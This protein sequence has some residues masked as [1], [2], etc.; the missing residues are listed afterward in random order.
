MDKGRV[1]MP[2]GL[3]SSLSGYLISPQQEGGGGAEERMKGDATEEMRCG[4]SVC[5]TKEHFF[6][7]P[8]SLFYWIGNTIFFKKFKTR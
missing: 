4:T 1:M 6:F 5:Q 7:L 2:D 3:L 8:I